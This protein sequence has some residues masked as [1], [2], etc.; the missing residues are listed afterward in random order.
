[1]IVVGLILLDE[2]WV[3]HLDELLDQEQTVSD[4]AASTKKKCLAE[5][6]D[7][8]L[9]DQ[10]VFEQIQAPE[11]TLF[12]HKI[13]FDLVAWMAERRD[14]LVERHKNNPWLWEFMPP[15][16]AGL[17][18]LALSR[19]FQGARSMFDFDPNGFVEVL[20][21][22]NRDLHLQDLCELLIERL[23]QSEKSLEHLQ[24]WMDIQSDISAILKSAA[25]GPGDATVTTNN[26]DLCKALELLDSQIESGGTVVSEGLNDTAQFMRRHLTSTKPHQNCELTSGKLQ[27]LANLTRCSRE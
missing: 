22:F 11:S 18:D 23:A 5:E 27:R 19:Q 7:A 4:R 21:A 12:I 14:P 25:V 17:T 9:A 1:M 6:I 2:I 15:K 10:S 16:D 8:S 3:P 24:C 26:P 20:S 13:W